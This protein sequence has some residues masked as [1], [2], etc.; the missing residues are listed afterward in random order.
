MGK[1]KSLSEA[2]DSRIAHNK[3]KIEA[4]QQNIVELETQKQKVIELNGMERWVGFQFESTD[5]FAGF[6]RDFKK[7]ILSVLPDGT[8]L[9]NW[10]KNHF[11]VSGFIKRDSKYVYFSI[12][13]VRFWQDAWYNDIM[14]RIAGH[15]EDYTGGRN[16]DTTLPAFI[17]AVEDLFARGW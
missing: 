4:L 11:E 12:R 13:D 8:E 7:H 16:C 3:A 17:E 5:E 15:E 6:A 2:I 9:V 10:N 1:N 14:V